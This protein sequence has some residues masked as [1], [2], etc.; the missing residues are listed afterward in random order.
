MLYNLYGEIMKGLYIHIP[1]CKTIC[2][3]CDFTKRVSNENNFI[4]YINRLSEEI[5]SYNDNLFSIDTV[6]IG[7][8]TPN[9]L[10]LALLEQLFKKIE[11]ILKVSKENTI[12]L[13]P[14]LI[15]NDLCILLKK[16]NFNRVSLGIQTVNDKSIKLLNRHHTKDD[17]I[18]SFKLL[19]EN[20][21][22]NINCDL[23]FGIPN[24]NID[25]VKNDLEFILNL[26]PTHISYYSLILEEKTI[27]KYQVDNNLIDMLDDDI[28]ADM[29][30]YIRDV[31]KN[32]N[33]IHYEISNFAKSGYES[34]HNKI[35]WN[36]EEYIGVGLGA[37]GYLGG[38]RYD[39][40]TD[41][42]AYF[43]TFKE[44]CYKLTIE[45]KKNEFMMLGLRLVSGVSINRYNELFNSNIFDD[46]KV[47]NELI[48]K[49]LLVIEKDNIK[50]PDDKLLLA[51]LVWSE[52][53]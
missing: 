27:L 20:G 29:Y 9:V 39:N 19:R 16:Y 47:I 40:N 26:N 28:V 48:N 18:N 46:F 17:V 36:V 5:D 10:P 30:D 49:G 32:N 53:V 24:T 15:T 25:D 14:E 8:G 22:N 50:I 12:E 44:N 21:I 31:L 43:K 1:F 42:K 34:I 11:N 13:N 7:G 3:Y 51:N 23:I 4:K 45:D 37:S 38:Y 41:L 35:Y 6:Y 52:F 33:Y 2:T